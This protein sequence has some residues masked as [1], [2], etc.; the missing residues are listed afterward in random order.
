ML[1]L[2]K[3]AADGRDHT[4][5]EAIEVL[6]E[7][8]KLT[9]DDRKDPLPISSQ[10][11]FDNRA[12]W[13]RTYLTKAGLL[14]TTGRGTFRLTGRGRDLVAAKPSMV[15]SEDLERYPEFL[16]FKTRPRKDLQ[17]PLEQTATRTPE[18]VLQA[19]YDDMR[20]ALAQ[21]VLDSVKKATPRFFEALVVEL[22]VAMGYGGSRVD[23]GQAVGQSGDGGIDGIIKE[24]RLG[25]DVIYIQAKRWDN[26]VGRP[27]LQGFVGS[28]EGHHARKG[29]FITT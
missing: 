7:Q 21:E 2:L 3:L 29:V 8:F 13:A 18:E 23:A 17:E 12:G 4:M 9:D 28:L 27:D 11:R 15:S 22:L 20:S 24:D 5:P 6:S 26:P 10:P 16:A 14:E 19:G 25:L 1:P